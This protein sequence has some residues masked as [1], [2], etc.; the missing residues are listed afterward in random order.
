VT[1]YF[2]YLV[3]LVATSVAILGVQ[4]VLAQASAADSSTGFPPLDQWKTAI[5]A[6]DA[7]GLKALYSTDPVAQVQANGVAAAA[8][9]T[10]GRIRDP[11][12]A[13]GNGPPAGGA[14]A[15]CGRVVFDRGYRRGRRAAVCND[16]GPGGRS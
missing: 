6:G 10:A 16:P 7:A 14:A 9:W 3:V 4:Y 8:E 11:A 13:N 15:E 2:R 1:G 5:V 12:P